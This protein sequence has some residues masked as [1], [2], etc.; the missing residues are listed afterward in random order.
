MISC[1]ATCRCSLAD[2]QSSLPNG[3]ALTDRLRNYLLSKHDLVHDG[4]APL[5]GLG[6]S[7]ECRNGRWWITVLVG[8]MQDIDDLWMIS[9]YP[10]LNDTPA[11]VRW[12]F[13]PDDSVSDVANKVNESLVANSEVTD[14]QW[15]DAN[16]F[17]TRD[18][19]NGD[20]NPIIYRTEFSFRSAMN[21]KRS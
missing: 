21:S 2:P 12:F 18:F 5:Y 7:L 10:N 9:V 14:L 4:T 17:K 3:K 11:Y 1:S 13:R 8:Q 16:A 15:H 19:S 6:H 20:S